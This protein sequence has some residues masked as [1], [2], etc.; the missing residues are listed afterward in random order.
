MKRKIIICEDDTL[1]LDV[2]ELALANENQEVIPVAHSP[3][4]MSTIDEKQ[5]DLLI[6]DI[7]MPSLAGDE[8]VRQLKASEKYSS[9]KV[10]MMSASL[11]G[12]AIA[13]DC[14]ADAFLAKPFELGELEFLVDKLCPPGLIDI[15]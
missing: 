3:R 9:I 15:L 8:I 12:K 14:G 2:L 7:Q 5:P 11:Q 10:I 6:V 4:L 13:A 1:I